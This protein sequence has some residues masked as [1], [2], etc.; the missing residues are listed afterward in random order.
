MASLREDLLLGMG[1]EE[2]EEVE[3]EGGE[4]PGEG[5]G[6]RTRGLLGALSGV[7]EGDGESIWEFGDGVGLG[8]WGWGDVEIRSEG[9]ISG[10]D[11][12]KVGRGGCEGGSWIDC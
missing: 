4:S 1:D 6:S 5:L 9:L 7:G 2:E 12:E 3:E 11:G 8:V 10:G